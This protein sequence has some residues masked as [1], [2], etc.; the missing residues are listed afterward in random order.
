MVLRLMLIG[1]ASLAFCACSATGL[2]SDV[3]SGSDRLI[4]V[5]SSA[6]Q[7]VVPAGED[8]E[9]EGEVPVVGEPV[10][11]PAVPAPA[12]AAVP[13]NTRHQHA[14]ADKGNATYGDAYRLAV[15]LWHVA[16]KDMD[17]ARE[18]LSPSDARQVLLDQGVIDA[19]WDEGDGN[20]EHQSA[21]Y[22]FARAIQI[23]G[24]VMYTLTGSVRYAHRLMI[25]RNFFPKANPRQF[26]SGAGVLSAFRDCREYLRTLEE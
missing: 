25:D 26:M 20:V 18:S 3:T 9:D 7:D 14:L 10:A 5:A 22:L 16:R 17:K 2:S 13:T 15:I 1:L 12:A 4:A 11:P 23:K 19:S 6:G 21:A 24:G 8:D